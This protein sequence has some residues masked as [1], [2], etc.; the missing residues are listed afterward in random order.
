MS[1]INDSC[2]FEFILFSDSES[3]SD[4][5]FDLDLYNH[6]PICNNDDDDDDITDI[7]NRLARLSL[8]HPR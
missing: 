8:H 2:E 5:D 1:S 3:D 6:Q 7:I 4:C